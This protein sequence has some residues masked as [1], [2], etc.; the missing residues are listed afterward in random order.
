MATQNNI[1]ILI[2]AAGESS[3]MGQPKQLLPVNNDTLLQHAA[4]T[5]LNITPNVT[6][7]LGANNTTIQ[8]TLQHLP[9][10]HI[11]N[12][13][14]PR[15]MGTSIKAGVAQCIAST[16]QLDAILLMTCDQPLITSQHLQNIITQY[17]TTNK[18]IVA[19]TYNNTH[20]VRSEERRVGKE[21]RSR[22]SPYH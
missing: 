3:R 14:W 18:H 1:A 15:G 7:V 9:I 12:P 20:G 19:T 11:V 8:H 2:L 5:A 21:C 13:D 16:P 17:Q 4:T 22:W 6:V 10:Q